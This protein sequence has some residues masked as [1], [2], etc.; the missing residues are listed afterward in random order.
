MKSFQHLLFRGKSKVTLS[1]LKRSERTD[2]LELQADVH[3]NVQMMLSLQT[4]VLSFMM[5][6]ELPDPDV[7]EIPLAQC[8]SA[9]LL[10]DCSCRDKAYQIHQ[11]ILVAFYKCFIESILSF[12]IV[13]WFGSLSVSNRNTIIRDSKICRKI[14]GQ[15]QESLMTISNKRSK[16][17]DYRHT[18]SAQPLQ[19]VTLRMQI[20]II[21]IQEKESLVSTSIQLLNI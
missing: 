3:V 6:L 4:L 5:F 2:E 17:K 14:V 9:K 11:S 19:F 16:R 21:T 10:L 7:Q 8:Q 12:N 15:E 13:T 1:L 18:H 20:Q